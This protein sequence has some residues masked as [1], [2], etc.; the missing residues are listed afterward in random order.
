MTRLSTKPKQDPLP[1]K[2]RY[3][4][5][6]P[7]ESDIEKDEPFEIETIEIPVIKRLTFQFKKPVK[8]EF[9]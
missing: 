4:S 1:A 9:S 7:N 3:E 8:L 2:F 5:E 6:S